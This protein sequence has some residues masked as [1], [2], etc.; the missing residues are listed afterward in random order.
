MNIHSYSFRI[1][2]FIPF[3]LLAGCVSKCMFVGR[4]VSALK[5]MKNEEWSKH[6][7]MFYHSSK[8]RLK[9]IVFFSLQQ[10]YSVLVIKII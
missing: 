6:I 10:C 9:Q 7:E 5:M 8:S 3:P 4:S 1:A 2:E